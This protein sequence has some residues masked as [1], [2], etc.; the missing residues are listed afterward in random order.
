MSND[1]NKVVIDTDFF[2]K[3][4]ENDDGTIFINLMT[5]LGR[6]AVMHTYVY[7]EELIGSN[8]VKELVRK[9]IIQVMEYDDYLTD[10]RRS[11][12]RNFKNLYYWFHASDFKGDVYTYS[13]KGDDL[14]E[15][16]SALMAQIMNI[17]LMVSDDSN[18]KSIIQS[19]LSS[20][21]HPL[22]VFNLYDAFLN[23]ADSST[24]IKWKDIKGLVKKNLKKE[25]YNK[26]NKEWHKE[27]EHG[28]SE[29]F[30]T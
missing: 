23:I 3:V 11:Y 8:V 29:T 12:E 14:G 5:E 16:R 20:S 17:D 4:T 27:D 26:L 21:R 15:I 9:G 13:N 6:Q 1:K 25:K 7:N 22:R 30:E 28:T 18:A 24:T 19:R 10:D 2:L